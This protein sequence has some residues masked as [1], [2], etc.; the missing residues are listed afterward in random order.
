[1]VALLDT[2][3]LCPPLATPFDRY[4]QEHMAGGQSGGQ[5]TTRCPSFWR[6]TV[7][8]AHL[9]ANERQSLGGGPHG[10]QRSTYYRLHVCNLAIT[11][12]CKKGDI[13]RLR[14][15]L[16]DRADRL[17]GRLVENVVVRLVQVQGERFSPPSASPVRYIPSTLHAHGHLTGLK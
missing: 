13:G 7:L 17:P 4:T 12:P 1:M 9:A 5:R 6:L 11:R 2:G 16:L 14:R 10:I 15:E 8:T 3:I